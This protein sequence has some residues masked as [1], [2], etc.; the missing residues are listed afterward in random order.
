MVNINNTKTIQHLQIVLG[1]KRL[2]IIESDIKMENFTNFII[3]KKNEIKLIDINNNESWFLSTVDSY[4]KQLVKFKNI[5]FPLLEQF[6]NQ[7]NI[8]KVKNE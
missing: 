1:Q 5:T 7:F 4:F 6:L 3:T 8:L 2:A